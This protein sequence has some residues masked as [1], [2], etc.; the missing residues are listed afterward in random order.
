MYNVRATIIY[1]PGAHGSFLKLVLNHMA[2]VEY[3]SVA[4]C[5]IFDRVK[6]PKGF[7]FDAVHFPKTHK[8]CI[9]ISLKFEDRLL[10]TALLLSRTAGYNIN[11]YDDEDVIKK[12]KN[13]I[14]LSFICDKNFKKEVVT[15]K[16][17]REVFR[18]TIFKD[19][20]TLDLITKVNRSNN[21]II[22]I[23]LSAFYCMP[24]LLSSCIKVLEL[25]G[26]EMKNEDISSL[27][28]LF[29]SRV[30]CKNIGKDTKKIVDRILNFEKFNLGKLNFLQ[31]SYIDD[32]L[33]NEFGI[34]PLYRDAYFTNSTEIFET[35]NLK[36]SL[37]KIS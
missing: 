27:H 13:H 23:N 29:L 3:N 1:P 32:V 20:N 25:T 35:Y 22:E 28:S 19:T 31:E 10:Y 21:P 2:G 7:I 34:D 26:V 36:N 4:N 14:V 11:L 8:Q 5:N 15:R 33:V 16:D 6:Y 30:E 37:T 18:L 24:K 12:L 17:L 9:N